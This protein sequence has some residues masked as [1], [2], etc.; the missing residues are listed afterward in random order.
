MSDTAADGSSL[1]VKSLFVV[2]IEQPT[3]NA[4]TD[5]SDVALLL[6]LSETMGDNR[7]SLVICCPLRQ[8]PLNLRT[9]PLL[10]LC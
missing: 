6:C 1:F 4:L 5:V 8:L 2:H 9:Q 7:C 10:N 3:S